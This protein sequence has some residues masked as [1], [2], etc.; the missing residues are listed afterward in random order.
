MKIKILLV[1]VL[2]FVFLSVIPVSA[3]TS[4]EPDY[5]LSLFSSTE[6][7]YSVS[8]LATT[9]TTYDD[10]I[11][12]NSYTD[13]LF[14]YYLAHAE[15]PLMDFFIIRSNQY[16]YTLIAFS[17][18]LYGDNSLA[19]SYTLNYTNSYD[20][21]FVI[22]KS[23]IYLDD[24]SVYFEFNHFFLSTSDYF[25]EDLVVRPSSY[26]NLIRDD[27]IYLCYLFILILFIFYVFKV[28]Y[29]PYKK[30]LS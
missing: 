17:P 2:C 20:S 14:N 24:V 8:R 12:T 9:V 27:N 29:N 28:K 5:S 26:I 30:V 6:A 25:E 21:S 22:N 19:F 23:S 3:I 16:E 18:S 1:F 4:S 13:F 7:N 10:L 15:D 11:S